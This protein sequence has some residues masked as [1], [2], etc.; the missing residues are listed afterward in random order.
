MKK[1]AYGN[2][3]KEKLLA[4]GRDRLHKF[5]LAGNTVRGAI[6]NGTRMVNEMRVQHNLGILETLALGHA[7]LGAVL[8]TAN[9]KGQDAVNLRID[10]SG[11]IKGLS[12][13]ANAFGEVRGFLK[14]VP[15]PIDKPL[16]N[17]DL[18]PFFG[19]G[20]LIVTKYLESAKQPFA[21]RIA[22]KHGSIAKDLAEY[23]L[24]SEQIPT[25]FNLSVY[26][27]ADGE[28]TGA[29]GLFVQAMPGADENVMIRM[30][31]Q[32]QQMASIGTVMAGDADP[33]RLI[34]TE[35]ALFSPKFLED[36]RIEFFCR[37]TERSVR[38]KLRLLPMADLDDIVVHGPFPLE[39]RCHHC[40]TVYS[41]SREQME[42]IR[43]ERRDAIPGKA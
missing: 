1:K 26:F 32:I 37:C 11:P 41:F 30:E 15:I 19:A 5:T 6:V 43:Q 9:L 40:N 34:Q 16:E 7:Y 25:A 27:D 24:T 39:V 38:S 29:G 18:S 35:F 20:L 14:R 21:G 33:V 10:C 22:L 31:K 17:F 42:A 28:C 8:M 2:T 4:A 23:F 36:H 12:V 3:L 13:D